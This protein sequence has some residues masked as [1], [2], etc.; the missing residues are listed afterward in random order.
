MLLLLNSTLV[1][2]AQTDVNEINL[3]RKQTQILNPSC[4]YPFWPVGTYWNYDASFSFSMNDEYTDLSLYLS[5]SNIQCEVVQNTTN[6]LI[7][8][9]SPVSGSFSIDFEDF[10]KLSGTLKNTNLNG[11]LTIEKENIQIKT[12]DV[13]IQGRLSIN[14]VPVN[15]NIDALITFDPTY[16]PLHFPLEVGKEWIINGSDF[17]VV[18][19]VSLPGITKL[20]S[21]IPDEIELDYSLGTFDKPAVCFSY[22]NISTSLGLIP[23]YKIDLGE[24]LDCYYSPVIGNLAYV[25][26]EDN[27]SDLFD[28]EL[29][30]RLRSTNYVMPGSPTI[31][32]APLGPTS[33]KPNEAYEYSAVTT[34]P[35]ND[36][37]YY[38]FDWGDGSLSSWIGPVASGEAVNATKTWSERGSYRV[39]VKAKDVYGNECLWSDPLPVSMP[40]IRNRW[41][42]SFLDHIFTLFPR[43]ESIFSPF[44]LN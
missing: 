40:K 23:S 13:D 38:S 2:S 3:E 41:I 30:A 39:S 12:L 24:E 33:G 42:D 37:I 43:L 9:S 19:S 6:Y 29:D 22:E 14:Y 34:D 4:S 27:E 44:S 36:D 31:P 26:L 18:G 7:E 8:I 10:P 25:F 21:S 28:Y 20:F 15:L 5:M 1:F 17:T 32:D 35:E 16:M 11:F